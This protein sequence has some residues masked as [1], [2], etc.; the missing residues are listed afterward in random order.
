LLALP[1]HKSHV[2]DEGEH[3][4]SHSGQKTFLGVFLAVWLIDSFILHESTF[5]SNYLP[6]SIRA[7]AFGSIFT[8]AVLL[9][10]SGHVVVSQEQRPTNVVTSGAFKYVRHPI[11]LASI[12]FYLALSIATASLASLCLVVGIFVFYN[13]I[14]TYEERL[15]EAKFGD[16]YKMYELQTGKWFPKVHA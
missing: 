11:Y 13:Y 8:A 16:R 3:P 12:L 15:L 5:L 4:L 10:K 9:L 7:L 6:L 1:D 2:T 14:A